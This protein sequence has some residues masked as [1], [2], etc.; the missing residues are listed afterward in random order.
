[1]HHVTSTRDQS[2]RSLPQQ[3]GDERR[4]FVDVYHDRYR[5]MVQVASLTTGSNELAEELVQEAFADLYRRFD[6]LDNPDAYLHRAVMNRCT[7]W[8]RRR[9][10]ERRYRERRTVA[11]P[12]WSD[13][14]T[15]SVMQAVGR[16]PVRQ[17][18]AVVLRY[19]A[20]WS[21]A[22]IARSLD[23]RPGTVKSLLSRARTQLG[24]ELT[25]DD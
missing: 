11:A 10:T 15:V 12:P 19:F 4:S 17:R 13:P 18:A 7:S 24:K 22:E 6:S 14:D 21:E 5:T 9:V 3:G 20:D 25:D 2:A 23:C 1:M 16:L 8:V